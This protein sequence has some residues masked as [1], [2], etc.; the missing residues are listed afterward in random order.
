[1]ARQRA[2]FIASTGYGLGDDQGIGGTELLLTDFSKEL[3][4][5]DVFVGNALTAAKSSYLGGLASMTPYDEKSSIEATLF[6][7]PMYQVKVPA[8]TGTVQ[9]LQAPQTVEQ[10]FSL[11]VNDGT[12][13]TTTTGT[14]AS[15]TVS[16]RSLR[17]STRTEA[18][19]TAICRRATHR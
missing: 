18:S 13:A 11:T 8:G 19:A 16:T 14:T 10:T 15:T 6:G 7:L 3:V 4:K 17:S 5:G 1:M 9:T 2:V 12:V